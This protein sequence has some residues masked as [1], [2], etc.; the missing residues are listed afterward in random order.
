MRRG[1]I[2]YEWRTVDVEVALVQHANLRKYTPRTVVIGARDRDDRRHA[3]SVTSERQAGARCLGREPSVVPASVGRWYLCV[4]TVLI[5]RLTLPAGDADVRALAE[6]LI[7]AVDAG[8]AVS[9]LAPLSV[10]AATAWWQQL[11]SAAHARAVSLVARDESGIIGTVQL[12]PAWAPNQPFRADVVKMLVHRSAR[13]RGIGKQL[14]HAIEM[15]AAA[16]GFTL[17]TLDV[18]AGG[19][20]ESLYVGL[21]WTR[22]GMIPRYALDS[23]GT[24]HDAVFFYRELKVRSTT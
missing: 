12:Q 7:D 3:Q 21:G 4:V 11:F 13:R 18:K 14:M 2:K 17:L 22:V 10:E 15:A 5:E 16:D 19:A 20:A 1:A 6:L 9:F 24:P 8:A 23:N